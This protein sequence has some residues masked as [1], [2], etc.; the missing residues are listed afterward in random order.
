VTLRLA[1]V[2]C[3]L[4][5]AGCGARVPIRPTGTAVPDPSA[6]DAFTLATRACTGLKTVTAE[7]RLSGRAGGERLRGTLHAGLAAPASLRFEAVAPFGQPVFILAGRDNRATLLLPRDRRVLE[8]ASV[9]DLL[10]RLIGVG[11]NAGD[12]RY[13]LTGCL[14]ETPAPTDGRAWG[15][16]WRAVTLAGGIVAYVRDVAGAPVV[17]AADYKTWRVDYQAHQGGWPRQVRI[18]RAAD[19]GVDLIAAVDQ[20]QINV[21]LED[22]AFVVE[23][24]AGTSPMTLDDL[25]SVAPLKGTQ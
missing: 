2:G 17:V 1:L 10:E 9:S 25:R 19:D 21:P 5:L 3:L 15:R 14:A 4:G 20:L 12:L 11:L 8:D 6:T 24:P 13:I 23:T 18:R 22:R 16:D 7:L